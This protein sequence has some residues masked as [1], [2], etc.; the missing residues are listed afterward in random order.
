MAGLSVSVNSATSSRSKA[1][2]DPES[3][4]HEMMS[5]LTTHTFIEK[6]EVIFMFFVEQKSYINLLNFNMDIKSVNYNIVPATF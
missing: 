1:L 5:L 2:N 6:L 4:G 3:T